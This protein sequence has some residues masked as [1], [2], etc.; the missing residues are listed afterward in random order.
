[1]DKKNGTLIS[2]NIEATKRGK[3]NNAYEIE[4]SN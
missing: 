2:L 1:M 4:I 3:V